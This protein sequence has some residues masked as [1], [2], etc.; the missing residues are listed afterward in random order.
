[1]KPLIGLTGVYEP[2]CGIMRVHR[3]YSDRILAF[4]GVP[5][6]LPLTKDAAQIRA[7]V[8][9][10]DGVLFTGGGDISPHYYG[11][12]LRTVKD[13]TEPDRDAFELALFSEAVARQMPILGICRG[14]QLIAVACGA[15]LEQEVKEHADGISHKIDIRNGRLYEMC[16]CTLAEVNSFHMQ[17][18]VEWSGDDPL[19]L[20]ARAEDGTI[21]AIA[22][23]SYPF[24]LGVQ[25]HPER[26]PYSDTVSRGIFSSFVAA[27]S[28]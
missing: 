17:A 10:L 7:I 16:G 26:M 24:G 21:E 4:G 19:E 12:S 14:M 3:R 5:M 22:I 23:K 25:W 1:M 8:N 2:Q 20:C 9:K 13:Q 28:C 18:V 6:L 15:K 11:E 27:C